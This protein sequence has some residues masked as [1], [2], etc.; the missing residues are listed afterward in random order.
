MTL[1]VCPWES[2]MDSAEPMKFVKKSCL[3]AFYFMPLHSGQVS[4]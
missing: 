3:V 4:A 2:L 1:S